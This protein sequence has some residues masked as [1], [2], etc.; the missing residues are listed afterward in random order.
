MDQDLRI[1]IRTK[2]NHNFNNQSTTRNIAQIQS[3]QY[4]HTIRRKKKGK[5]GKN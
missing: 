4:M 3:N 2:P 5:R 1:P